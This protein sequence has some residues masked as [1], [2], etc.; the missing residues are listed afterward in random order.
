MARWSLSRPLAIL[1]ML[2][3]VVGTPCDAGSQILIPDLTT[4]PAVSP[5]EKAFKD[6]IVALEKKD[7][8][9]AEAAFNR[10]IKLDGKAAGP[11]LGLA[12]VVLARGQKAAAEQ[13]LKQAVTLAPDNAS[14]QTTWGAFL[15]S[16][17]ELPEAEAALRKALT[18]DPKQAAAHVH[19]GDMYLTA[20]RKPDEAIREYRAALALAPQHPGAHYAM[21]LALLAKND[22][23]QAETEFL[24]ASKIAPQNPLPH[25][26]LG[27]VYATQRRWD[28][29]LTAF[30]AAIKALPSFA[31]PHLE[32]GQI[33]AAK[34]DDERA[35]QEY[36]EAQRKDPKRAV[37]SLAIGMVHQRHQRWVQAEQAYLAALKIEPAHAVA[38][39]NL[40]WMA[41]DRKVNTTQ[42]LAWARKAVE[43]APKVPEFHGTLA[44][45]YRAQGDLARAER[46]L[47]AAAAMTP[48]RATIVYSLG[49]IYLEE[50]KKA[51]AL[52]EMQKALAIDPKFAGA[53]EARKTLKELGPS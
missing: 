11:Y 31:A 10:S 49:R 30:D 32:R 41:A 53:D 35:I 19:L 45:V 21:G 1:S 22:L 25:H 8:S 3:V 14:I 36:A 29:A 38:Y 42:A 26:A 46:T 6:G 13:Y 18:L 43:L 24:A 39:N 33:F 28:E 17:K 50:G 48:Q 23:G 15:Y 20:F 7:L 44:W 4:K 27:R 52:A 47:R 16:Q 37:G 40:A 9:S 2:A 5:A 34:G 12:Q 51:L